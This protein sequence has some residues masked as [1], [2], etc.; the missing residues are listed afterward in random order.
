[1]TEKDNSVNFMQFLAEGILDVIDRNQD[2]DE[3]EL[4]I[5][6]RGCKTEDGSYV[7]QN[8]QFEEP[9]NGDKIT[10]Q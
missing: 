6:F 10:Y 8:L 5:K 2:T 9:I 1:M 4:Y 7:I 3:F